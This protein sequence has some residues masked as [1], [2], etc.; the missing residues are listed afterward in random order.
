MVRQVLLAGLATGIARALGEHADAPP[1]LLGAGMRD[2]VDREA[3]TAR[4]E[5]RR[6]HAHGGRL[7]RAVGTEDAENLARLDG[8]GQIVD[9]DERSEL[10]CDPARLDD[11][12]HATT[13]PPRWL[14]RRGY[15]LKMNGG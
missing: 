8:D 1:D 14:D 2:P 3:P 4:R 12:R 9:G 11:R 7:A 15:R 10:L 6:Q 13:H 5:D